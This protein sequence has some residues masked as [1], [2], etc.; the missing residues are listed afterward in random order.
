MLVSRQHISQS[1][2]MLLRK[3]NLAAGAVSPT[4]K[5]WLHEPGDLDDDDR[6]YLVGSQLKC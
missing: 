5:M 2:I 3:D 1:L 4:E 6:G